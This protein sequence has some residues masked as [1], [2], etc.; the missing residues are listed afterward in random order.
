MSDEVRQR[1][2]RCRD[3][4][5]VSRAARA[6][7]GTWPGWPEVAAATLVVYVSA[8][9][10]P[11]TETTGLAARLGLAAA[12]GLFVFL[13][14]VCALA[15]LARRRVPGVSVCALGLVCT[16]QVLA[17]DRL[18]LTVVLAALL[19][20][21]TATSRVG[22][23][24][25]WVLL[26]A[27]YLGAGTGILRVGYLGGGQNL[28]SFRAGV[29]LATSWSF[30]TVAALTGLLRRR[31]R[32]R[33]EQAAE[34]IELLLAQRDAERALAIARERQRI[35]H[36][37]HDVVGHSLAVIGIQAEA[38]RVVMPASPT[39]ADEALEVI[40]QTS[41]RAI[42]EVHTLVDVLRADDAAAPRAQSQADNAQ[43][44]AP[45]SPLLPPR[46]L[47]ADRPVPTAQT[48]VL[49][50]ATPDAPG[51][52][53]LVPLVSTLRGTGLPVSVDLHDALASPCPA[54]VAQC[55]YRVVQEAT[56]NA[57][58]HAPGAAICV[59]VRGANDQLEVRVANAAPARK[60][61]H[62]AHAGHEVAQRQGAGLE[63]MAARV[64][65]LGGRLSAGPLAEGWVVDATIPLSGAGER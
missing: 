22:R 18:S 6:A 1:V 54:T 17:W 36:E 25:S 61:G 64:G 37:V 42:D 5:V 39:R 40:A 52:E 14:L 2:R 50:T 19:A 35:A 8:W 49:T 48:R 30:L 26:T 51:L 43:A 46:R 13:V 31:A 21:Q 47:P 44:D 32:E 38:A 53:G 9:N 45:G 20:A 12:E 15:I 63:T 59:S 4:L 65:D 57:L 24:W 34:R 58:R 56:T 11:D 7:A 27:G 55:V 33:R 10:G 23:P 41:R 62:R 16:V 29:L 60:A 28:E 3:R